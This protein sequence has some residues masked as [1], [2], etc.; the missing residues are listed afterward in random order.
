MNTKPAAAEMVREINTDVRIDVTT[1]WD[2]NT[3][4]T[5]GT[6]RFVIGDE[7]EDD[8]IVAWTWTTY[9]ASIDAPEDWEMISTDGTDDA[10]Q[11]RAAL[12]DWSKAA[13][14]H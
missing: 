11:A 1:D 5:I 8:E 6:D 3:I 14:A 2:R 12:A 9:A 13:L 10:E 4:V 7:Y